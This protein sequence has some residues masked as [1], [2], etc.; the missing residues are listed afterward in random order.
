LAS[1]VDLTQFAVRFR[2]PG[3]EQPGLEE[4]RDWLALARKTYQEVRLRLPKDATD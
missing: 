4:A 1:A 3:E 2:Y